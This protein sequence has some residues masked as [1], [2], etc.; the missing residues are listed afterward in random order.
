MLVKNIL[1]EIRHAVRRENTKPMQLIEMK[2]F[3]LSSRLTLFSDAK[4]RWA[5]ALEKLVMVPTI[6]LEVIFCGNCYH[7]PTLF[8]HEGYVN[9]L[10]D[11]PVCDKSFL[12]SLSEDGGL[13]PEVTEWLVRGVPVPIE[14]DTCMVEKSTPFSLTVDEDIFAQARTLAEKHKALFLATDEMLR[15]CVP[16]E[17]DKV[18]VLDEWHHH[19]PFHYLLMEAPDDDVAAMV[20]GVLSD[21]LLVN[22]ATF[23][24]AMR[25]ESWEQDD[26]LIRRY[27]APD[28]NPDEDSELRIMAAVLATGDKSLYK[29]VQ[30]PNS[31]PSSRL[32]SGLGFLFEYEEE[33]FVL[34]P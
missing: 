18:L 9:C 6:R 26:I 13:R 4:G 11:H 25:L 23:T 30:L 5:M 15:K 16:V 12:E 7:V 2:E 1:E 14:Y 19:D 27:F 20:F 21:D 10:V 33:P 32:G 29:P 24:R 22:M 28:W 3:L 17:V 34:G 31:A 8:R